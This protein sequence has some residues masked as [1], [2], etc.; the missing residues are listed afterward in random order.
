MLWVV[1]VVSWGLPVHYPSGKKKE[2]KDEE[3]KKGRTQQKEI[4]E[5]LEAEPLPDIAHI[6]NE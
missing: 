3:F 6:F 4:E 5:V 2:N 1:T